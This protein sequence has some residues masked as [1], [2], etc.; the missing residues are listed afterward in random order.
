M[1]FL[2]AAVI[3]P[4]YT[5]FRASYRSLL[6]TNTK[7]DEHCIAFF[8]ISPVS[9]FVVQP[10]YLYTQYMIQLLVIGILADIDQAETTYTHSS[11]RPDRSTLSRDWKHGQQSFQQHWLPLLLS[12]LYYVCCLDAYSHDM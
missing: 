7:D 11:W 4:S 5:Q 10:C 3:L 8:N 1:T 12:P 9:L 6:P 2:C